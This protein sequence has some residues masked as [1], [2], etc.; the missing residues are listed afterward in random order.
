MLLQEFAAED[1]DRFTAQVDSI[2]VYLDVHDSAAARELVPDQ[3]GFAQVALPVGA[4]AAVGG[5]GDGVFADPDAGGEE[6]RDEISPPGAGARG[7]DHTP[8]S[9]IPQQR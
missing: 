4:E 2:P 8:G 9:N 1:G 7:D 6:A 5:A 3:I